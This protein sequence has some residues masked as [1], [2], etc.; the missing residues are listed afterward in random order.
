MKRAGL[1]LMF[2]IG[3]WAQGP[4]GPALFSKTCGTG[5]C[6]ATRGV[7]G[8]A[9]R[10]A[11][12]G[13]TQEF[14]RGVVTNGVPGT[15]M[16]AYGTTMARGELAAVIGYVASL[17]GVSAAGAAPRPKSFTGVAGRGR[18]LFSET[19]RG[20]A[21]C[22]TCHQVNGVGIAVAA[23]M[24]QVPVSVAALKAVTSPQVMTARVAGELVPALM[25]AR[26]A[27]EAEFYELPA[28]AG[29]PVLRTLPASEV[30]FTAGATWSHAAAMAGYTD[31]DLTAILAFLKAA[32]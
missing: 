6:H 4:D 25:V 29:P 8:G 11:A 5:Y 17:N 24:A 9:P 26:R 21:R 15:A 1:M 2:A 19:T 20:F 22:S 30:A 10:L 27:Q 13:F 12:R 18:V 23:P 3:A 31:A 14:I 16:A 32:Q 7:G 28:T